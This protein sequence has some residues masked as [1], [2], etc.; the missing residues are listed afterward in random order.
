[1]TVCCRLCQTSI[2]E[3]LLQLSI[4]VHYDFHTFAATQHSRHYNS[5]DPNMRVVNIVRL[6]LLYGLSEANQTISLRA[7]TNA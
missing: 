4:A 5:L 6:L 3:V 7:V 2:N 1:M